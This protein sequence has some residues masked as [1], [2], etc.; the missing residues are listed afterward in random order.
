MR[1][2]QSIRNKVVGSDDAVSIIR[3]WQKESKKVVFTN[4]CFDILHEGHATYLALSADQGDKLVIGLNSDASVRKQG[5]GDDR[6]VNSESSRALLLAALGFVDLVVLFDEDTP[7]E[8]IIEFQ[9]DVLLKG[10]DYDP[11]E[12][13]ETSKRYIVGSKEVK[14]YGGKVDVIPLVE[15]FS[16][17]SILK[18]IKK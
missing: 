3:E 17:T 1:T 8:L 5:K 9:P 16:T 18:R 10:A 14:S 15:G 2:L 4:G 6:P 13:D 7:L 12:V 11:D